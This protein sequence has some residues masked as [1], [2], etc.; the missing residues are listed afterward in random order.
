MFCITHYLFPAP[1]CLNA[2]GAGFILT[3][4]AVLG[5]IVCAVILTF[6]VRSLSLII[7]AFGAGDAPL[8]KRGAGW[9]RL[10]WNS[11]HLPNAVWLLS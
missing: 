6:G 9:L 3:L 2:S 5:K 7:L 4:T 10:F 11:F 8:E 1:L